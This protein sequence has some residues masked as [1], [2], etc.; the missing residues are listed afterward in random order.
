LDI[1]WIAAAFGAGLAARAVRMP[2]LV[3]YLAAGLVLALVGVEPSPVID[4][5]GDFGVV[6]LLFTIGLHLSFGSL[7][8]REV[9]G[10]GAIHL[11][12]SA[13]LFLPLGLAFG[14]GMPAAALLAVGLGFSS[15]VLT[16]KSLDARGELDTFHGRLAIGIL[17]L[18]DVVA[19]VLLAAAGSGAPSPWG[20]ALLLL[21]PARPWLQRLMRTTGRDELLLLFGLLMALGVGALFEQVGLD[22]KL[23]ALAAGMLLAGDARAEELHNRLWA[24]KEVF[25]VGFFLNVGLGGL[26]DARGL[27]SVLVLLAILP[28]KGFAFFALMVRFG[29]RA[30][31][32]FL[33]SVSLTAYSEFALIVAV[34]AAA[35]GRVEEGVVGALGLLVALSYALN[36]PVSR[37][38]NRLWLR[39]EDRLTVWERNVEHPDREPETLGDADYVVLGMGRAGSAAYDYLVEQGARPIGLDA[40]P[41]QIERHREEGRLVIYGDAK[42]PELWTG[43]DL[44]NIRGVLMA[45][46]RTPAAEATASSTLRAE[47]YE[48]FIA[49]LMRYEENRTELDGARVTVSFLPM[50]QAGRELAQACLEREASREAGTAAA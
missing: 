33:A 26:P 43:L 24:L 11:L 36:A 44:S 47:G 25:L 48:G 50:A 6:L 3:G 15:T 37:A 35:S 23:G 14:L 9:L 29:L 12:L 49:A 10:V 22:A 41:D 32:S 1:I 19:V 30:R 21:V 4:A 5:V 27:L 7:L 18:Q 45:I 40:D 34:A 39:L 16:A 46:G 8:Q 20:L 2:T 17:V 28:L 38:V 42:D 13:L 31:T